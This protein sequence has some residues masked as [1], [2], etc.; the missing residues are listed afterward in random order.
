MNLILVSD[1][2][3][4]KSGFKSRL[5]V[6]AASLFSTAFLAGIAMLLPAFFLTRQHLDTANPVILTEKTDNSLG[7]ELATFPNE[8]NNKLRFLQTYE[9]EPHFVPILSQVVANLPA[10]VR[11]NSILINKSVGKD[12]SGT[13]LLI[14]GVASTR[15]SLI[16]YGESLRATKMFSS[17]EVPVSSLTKDKDLPFSMKMF[18]AK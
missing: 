9:A 3:L 6:L 14:S 7:E 5:F 4:L 18:I 15:E 8:I 10:N 13:N 2:N 11:L 12:K 16:S 1:K 17:V